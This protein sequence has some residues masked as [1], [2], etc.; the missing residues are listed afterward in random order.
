MKNKNSRKYHTSTMF[1]IENISQF[2]VIIEPKLA[3]RNGIK[4]NLIGFFIYKNEQRYLVLWV[5]WSCPQSSWRR[6]SSYLKSQ[7]SP[8]R[9]CRWCSSTPCARSPARPGRFSGRWRRRNRSRVTA[10]P[11]VV[12]EPVRQCYHRQ[13][14][15]ISTFGS[16][17]Q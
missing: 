2:L 10:K 16:R 8:Q 7:P 5:A 4:Y 14:P 17:Y 12:V 6:A 3:K 9:R 11:F 1:H 13:R 15:L